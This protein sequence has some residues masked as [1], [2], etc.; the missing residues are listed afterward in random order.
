MTAMY[1]HAVSDSRGPLNFIVLEKLVLKD[2]VIISSGNSES[3]RTVL[4]L[5]MFLQFFSRLELPT[6]TRDAFVRSICGHV[7]IR[8]INYLS[9]VYKYGSVNGSFYS[10]IR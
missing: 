8:A 1:T 7:F 3:T 4:L 2:W 9:I 10:G 5:I 6:V